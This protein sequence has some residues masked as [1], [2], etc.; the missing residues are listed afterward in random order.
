MRLEATVPDS[1][2]ATLLELASDLGLTKSQVIDEALALF[3]EVILD[4]R[5]GR[6]LV[7]SG[8]G[9]EADLI[10]HPP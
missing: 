10:A 6:C 4:A 7:A 1:R 5:N 2:G 3:L 8:Q 9:C